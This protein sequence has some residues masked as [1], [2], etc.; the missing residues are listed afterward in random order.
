MSLKRLLLSLSVGVVL[1]GAAIAQE[2]PSD[3]SDLVG[4]KA[5]GGETQLERRGYKFVKSEKGE[6]RIWSNWWN[7]SK[8]ICINVVTMEGRYDSIAS[9]GKFDCNQADGN[10][11]GGTD[12]VDLSD[13]VGGRAAGGENLMIERGFESGSGYKKGSTSYVYWLN[14][15]TKQCVLV[16]TTNGRYASINNKPT[17]ECATSAPTA[18][19]DLSDLV[20]GRAAGGE[21]LLI[22]RGFESG[23]GYKKGS[24]SYVYWLNSDTKQCVLVATA[25]GRYASINNKPTGECGN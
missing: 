5:A 9:V 20:G 22:E 14:S 19:V 23:R 16:A 8:K 13:L 18:L 25:N 21:S 1:A 3:L 17:G 4:A 10:T 12:L 24:T 7:P 15:D 6:D 11:S 2:T